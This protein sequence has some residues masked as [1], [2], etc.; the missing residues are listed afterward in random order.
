[1]HC[2]I[3]HLTVS[4]G[5]TLNKII[6]EHPF[7]PESTLP[8]QVLPRV[9]FLIACGSLICSLKYKQLH[10]E[11]QKG[12]L[13]FYFNKHFFILCVTVILPHSHG[14]QLL[15]TSLCL[16]LSLP[17][18]LFLSLKYMHACTNTHTV[19][20]SL[21]TLAYIADNKGMINVILKCSKI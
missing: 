7:G 16:C 3:F 2:F 5:T 14:A 19:S 20:L 13:S 4:T 15:C 9:P 18:S 8:S 6:A 11:N 21:P 10:Q 17:L 12:V 1:M